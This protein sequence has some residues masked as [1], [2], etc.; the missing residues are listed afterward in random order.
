M[1]AV[2]ME[3]CAAHYRSFPLLREGIQILCPRKTIHCRALYMS[4]LFVFVSRWVMGLA[5]N[6]F[7]VAFMQGFNDG[8][9]SVSKQNASS[10]NTHT[11]SHFSIFHNLYLP[12]SFFV[13]MWF[14]NILYLSLTFASWF[15]VNRRL[16]LSKFLT[17]CF[18]LPLFFCS[19]IKTLVITFVCIYCPFPSHRAALLFSVLVSFMLSAR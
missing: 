15:H 10:T 17:V 14:L 11:E 3:A 16:T 13:S 18:S 2:W 6:K 7:W 9:S 1:R 19:L 12:I 4:A 8:R 5:K